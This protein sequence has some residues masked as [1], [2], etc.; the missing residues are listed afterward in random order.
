M[1]LK[2]P[3]SFSRI[4]Q[5]CGFPEPDAGKPELSPRRVLAIDSPEF[6]T[7]HSLTFLSSQAPLQVRRNLIAAMVL[8]ELPDEASGLAWLQ[9]ASMHRAMESIL[10]Y[11]KDRL[12]PFPPP[13]FPSHTG[14]LS[15]IHPT[16]VVEGVLAEDVKVGPGCYV[17]KGSFIG[18]G[19]VLEA[20]S[21]VMENCLILGNCVLQS[22]VVVG[23]AGFGFYPWEERLAPMP[24][25]AGV[26]V[27]EDVWIGANSVVA[28]GVLHSTRIGIGS[29]L[30][31][32]VQ[33]AHN[34]QLG[35]GAVLAS[36][37]GIAG[38]TQVG[39]GLRMGG[40][41]AI[42]GHLRIGK[43][44]SLAAFSAITKNVGDGVTLAG[45][46]AR[47]IRE[48]R[49]EKIKSKGGNDPS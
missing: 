3:L 49:R 34:V 25:Y 19:T 6:S 2:T 38:S 24:H 7:P 9:V 31:S 15:Q 39:P 42:A 47:P 21:T 1:L 32:H 30:D 8:S 45:F 13:V 20:R 35:A 43:G 44:V 18:P 33:V 17:G 16:A 22:G 27:E 48:W 5:L 37:A 12:E 4:A 36:G 10:L 46:P 14:R 28:A 23:S 29:R 41:S 26:V 11:C 40:G